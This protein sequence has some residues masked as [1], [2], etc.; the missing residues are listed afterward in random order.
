MGSRRGGPTQVSPGGS[1]GC[2]SE[3]GVHCR[4]SAGLWSMDGSP[5]GDPPC[6]TPGGPLE[7]SLGG[8]R[9]LR[10]HWRGSVEG[11]P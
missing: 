2:D 10:Y 6:V 3:M 11:Y 5:G 9:L 1:S 4:G 7:G 8:R